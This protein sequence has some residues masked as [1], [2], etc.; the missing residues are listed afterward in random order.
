MILRTV[1]SWLAAIVGLALV[2]RHF[3]LH[4]FTLDTTQARARE[5]LSQGIGKYLR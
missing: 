1:E 5:L 2:T 4:K 3:R